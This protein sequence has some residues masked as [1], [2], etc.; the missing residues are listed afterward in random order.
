MNRWQKTFK[1]SKTTNRPKIKIGKENCKLEHLSITEPLL[2]RLFFVRVYTKQDL[3]Y[4]YDVCEFFSGINKEH[5]QGR[6]SPCQVRRAQNVFI[7]PSA[8]WGL[9][10]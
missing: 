2:Y 7:R 10:Q 4:V 8:S 1:F 5:A 6:L 3:G 9:G